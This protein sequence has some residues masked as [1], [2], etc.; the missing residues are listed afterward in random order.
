MRRYSLSSCL[1]T[2]LT[3]A[4]SLVAASG[5]QAVVIDTNPAANGQAT[6]TYPTD[7]SSYVG[8]TSPTPGSRP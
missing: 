1:A 7:Q 5:A 6:V 4:V 8:V 3:L 2:A